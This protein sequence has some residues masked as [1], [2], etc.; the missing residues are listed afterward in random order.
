MTKKN[1]IGATIRSGQ[2]I[3][4]LPMQ[5]FWNKCF[6]AEQ[7]YL[8]ELNKATDKGVLQ[9][10]GNGLFPMLQEL[11][12]ITDT[13]CIYRRP[14]IGTRKYNTKTTASVQIDIVY[15]FLYFI[16]GKGTIKQAPAELEEDATPT[17]LI[18]VVFFVNIYFY[19]K[20][21]AFYLLPL[22]F[23]IILYTLYLLHF[24]FY[25]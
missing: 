12:Y 1:G 7:I 9:L 20:L 16:L 8:D 24:T 3:Q 13:I 19:I 2:E 23:C 4:C 25:L 22:N 10:K 18:E 5:D 21:F 11:Q 14:I 15:F 6:Y 17:S